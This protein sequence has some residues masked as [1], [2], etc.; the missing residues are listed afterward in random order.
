MY[1]GLALS[2]DPV[3]SDDLPMGDLRLRPMA[4]K[5][6]PFFVFVKNPSARLWKVI[7]EVWEGDKLSAWAGT[8]AKPL[9]VQANSSPIVPAFETAAP[10]A[11]EPPPKPDAPLPK[12]AGPLRLRLRD[13]AGATVDEQPIRLAIAAPREYIE[14]RKAQFT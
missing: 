4:G 5:R 1:P 7:V 6:Q 2:S 11:G 10:K 12:L 14:V 3:Q 13:V 9:E 8:N